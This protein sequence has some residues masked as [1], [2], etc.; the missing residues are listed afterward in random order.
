[1]DGWRDGWMNWWVDGWTERNSYSW[2][3]VSSKAFLPREVYGLVTVVGRLKRDCPG[4]HPAS[5]LLVPRVKDSLFLII[6]APSARAQPRRPP[7][8]RP[9]GTSARTRSVGGT[10]KCSEGQLSPSLSL[11]LQSRARSCQGRGRE[12]PE[13][14]TS[15]GSGE[16]GSLRCSARA[17]PF[18]NGVSLGHGCSMAR[19]QGKQTDPAAGQAVM[20]VDPSV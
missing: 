11:D 5:L 7:P 6:Q 8:E 4:L 12:L 18:E 20:R 16:T 13:L 15:V 10:G 2:R 1:M 3:G 17:L 19:S 14:H 9:A